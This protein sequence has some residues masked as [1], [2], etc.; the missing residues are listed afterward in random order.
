[1]AV[2]RDWPVH[3]YPL[4]AEPGDDLSATTSAAERVA[5][6]W[7][8][9]LEV[10]E[11]SGRDSAALLSRASAGIV[12]ADRRIRSGAPR[13]V[14]EDF[15]DLLAALIEAG[16]RFLVVGAHGMAVHGVPRATGDLDLWIAADVANAE[17]VNN[18]GSQVTVLLLQNATGDSVGGNVYFWD[19]AGALIA[20]SAFTLA[21]RQLLVLNTATV[22]PGL[23]GAMTIAHDGRF[24]DLAGKTVALEPATGFSFDSPMV[25]CLH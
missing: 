15:R 25:P 17:R 13:P 5:M 7:A 2:R 10:W 12:D 3:V 11:L 24:G 8:L 9:T 4:G 22:A 14:N 19:T 6:V 21:P 1:V 18:A 23:G 20:P 16:A